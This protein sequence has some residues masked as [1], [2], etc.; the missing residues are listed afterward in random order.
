MSL[1]G[2]KVPPVTSRIELSCSGLAAASSTSYFVWW[3]NKGSSLQQSVH[4]SAQ[5]C[6]MRE[7]ALALALAAVGPAPAPLPLPPP[8]CC[9]FPSWI[10]QFQ[11]V[12]KWLLSWREYKVIMRTLQGATSHHLNK[13]WAQSAEWPS[14]VLVISTPFNSR[15]FR[16][17]KCKQSTSVPGRV[18]RHRDSSVRT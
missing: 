1:Q 16:L 10:F 6:H 9:C 11:H 13:Y 17:S 4:C 5:W 12:E 18:V 2:Y 15:H 14:L 7:T 8:C 3:R